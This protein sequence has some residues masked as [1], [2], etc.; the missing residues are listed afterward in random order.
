MSVR[1]LHAER[2][3]RVR[4]DQAGAQLLQVIKSVR[5]VLKL[6][7]LDADL[8]RLLEQREV[9][10][11]VVLAEGLCRVAAYAGDRLNR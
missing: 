7:V 5:V 11:H 2:R 1:V 10:D 8:G 4:L 3:L 9:V 6:G